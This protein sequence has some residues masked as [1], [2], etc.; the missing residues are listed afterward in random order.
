MNTLEDLLLYINSLNKQRGTYTKDELI[1]IGIKHRNLPQREKNW[2]LLTEYIG[3][4]GKKDSYRLFVLKAAQ[5]N[6]A[7][8]A[9]TSPQVENKSTDVDMSVYKEVFKDKVKL[10]EILNDYHNNLRTEA[11]VESFL[12]S[13][14]EAIVPFAKS[15]PKKFIITNKETSAEAILPFADL[16]LGNDTNNYINIFNSDVAEL[17]IQKIVSDTINYC[18]INNVQTLHFLNLG[19]M[20]SGL[21]HETLRYGQKLNVAEQLMTAVDLIANM[22]YQLD[23]AIPQVTYRSVTDNHSRLNANKNQNIDAENL[24]LI[25]TEF[26]KLKL[27]NTN[28]EFCENNIDCSIGKFYLRTGKCVVYA[29]GDKEKKASVVQDTMGLLREFPDYIFLAHYHNA[30]EHT[31]QGAKVFITGSICGTDNYAFSHRLFGDPEQKLLIFK[32]N[33]ILNISIMLVDIE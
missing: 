12:D 15:T 27:A 31:F 24:N 32:D 16:H 17:R 1:D 23:K 20:V 11:K 33:N 18:K 22:L 10:R 4:P 5:S 2:A 6:I 28:V 21:I 13:L 26:L 7:D 3:Y 14:K 29:H 30:A 9:S 8:V 25:L 19:D